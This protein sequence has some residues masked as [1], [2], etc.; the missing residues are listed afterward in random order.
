MFLPDG[1]ALAGTPL[2]LIGEDVTFTIEINR[3]T[4]GVQARRVS[5]DDEG[6]LDED[7]WDQQATQ[8]EQPIGARGSSR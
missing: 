8:S 3:W 7:G 2:Y 6:G 1:T 4:G 5:A